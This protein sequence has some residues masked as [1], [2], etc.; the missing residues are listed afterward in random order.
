VANVFIA[1]LFVCGALAASGRWVAK[2][3][4]VASVIDRFFAVHAFA[5]IALF[6]LALWT[7]LRVGVVT[8]FKSVKYWPLGGITAISAV[9]AGI[10]LG[11]LLGMP[12]EKPST[13]VTWYWQLAGVLAIYAAVMLV[14]IRVHVVKA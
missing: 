13:R 12:R 5:G 9:L 6:A 8:L 11:A 14:L 3:A 7:W 4:G 10:V 2:R 1:L